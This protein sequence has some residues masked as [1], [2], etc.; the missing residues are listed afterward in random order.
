VLAETV[1]EFAV[2][3]LEAGELE[4]VVD[5]EQQLIGGEGLFEEIESAEARGL[6]GHFDVG[7]ARDQDDGSLQAGFFQFF[8]EFEAAFAWHDHVGE[9]EVEAL[10]LDEFGGA[11]SII[12]NGGLVSGKAKGAGE[13]CEG[14]GVVVDQEEMGFA[15]HESPFAAMRNAASQIASRTDL[16]RSVL[17]PYKFLVGGGGWGGLGF[18]RGGVFPGF[19][20]DTGLALGQIDAK[21]GAASFLT[22]N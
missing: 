8:K 4:S 12:A 2:F 3:V 21:R 7:L 10:V 22:G 9:D 1:A 20:D 5:G 14:V 13:G 17:R 6:H 15:W 11:K 19:D 18:V 16:G